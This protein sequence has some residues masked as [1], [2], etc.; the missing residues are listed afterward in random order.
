MYYTFGKGTQKEGFLIEKVVDFGEDGNPSER[1]LD[2]Y[3]NPLTDGYYFSPVLTS[4]KWE[5]GAKDYKQYM[6]K[7][8]PYGYVATTDKKSIM[9]K[10]NVATFTTENNIPEWRELTFAEYSRLP[11]TPS[12][13]STLPAGF[14]KIKQANNTFNIAK[15]PVNHALLDAA[16]N[17]NSTYLKY[18]GPQQPSSLGEKDAPPIGKYKI[19][20]VKEYNTN[21]TPKTI[22]YAVADIPTK[23][24]LDNSDDT[25]TTLL[26]KKSITDNF[27]EWR[28]W[29]FAEYTQVISTPIPSYVYGPGKTGAEVPPTPGNFKIKKGDLYEFAPIPMNHRLLGPDALNPMQTYLTYMGSYSDIPGYTYQYGK[30]GVPD[31]TG[32]FALNETKTALIS[33]SIIKAPNTGKYKI[34]LVTEYNLTDNTEKKVKYVVAD[35]PA[36]YALDAA[37][38]TFT[39]LI[40]NIAKYDAN[41]TDIQYNAEVP[42]GDAKEDEQSLE[43]GIYYQF[44]QNGKLVEIQYK[45]SNFAPILY[46]MPGAYKFGSSAYVPT[47]EDSVYLSRSNR[48]AQL[49]PGAT[50]EGGKGPAPVYNTDSQLGG[51]CKANENDKQKIEEK[52]RAIEP[53]SCASTSCCVL[54]GGQKCVAGNEKGPYMTANYTDYTLAPRNRDFYYFQGKC[55]GNCLG[56]KN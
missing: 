42:E 16:A 39:K 24:A 23:Y 8:L 10:T 47:Y 21:N 49:L 4:G 14:F 6:L 46:Y 9:P 43:S 29:T 20:L 37:D 13:S 36:G 53:G 31:W 22:V 56:D 54:L 12:T 55:Y 52:C 7:S 3:N 15:I 35:I 2:E 44:D 30:P 27:P 41:N 34:K 26:L 48:N 1:L 40:S 5:T 28:E 33:P 11:A 38:P 25:F 32:E 45:D 19:R 18:V 17:P 50:A 51:F